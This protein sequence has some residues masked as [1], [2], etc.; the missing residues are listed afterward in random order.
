VTIVV[1]LNR[2]VNN[3]AKLGRFSVPARFRC[4]QTGD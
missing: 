2:G 3:A 1:R 4:S